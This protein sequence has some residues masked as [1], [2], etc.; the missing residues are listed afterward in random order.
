MYTLLVFYWEKII[1]SFPPIED[2]DRESIRLGLDWCCPMPSCILPCMLLVVPTQ[3]SLDLSSQT[4]ALH[5]L[6]I[7]FFF[8]HNLNRVACNPNGPLHQYIH[9]TPQTTNLVET[10]NSGRYV[11]PCIDA[12]L[13]RYKMHSNLLKNKTVIHHKA[14]WL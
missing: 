7:Y 6:Y 9:V 10:G 4:F 8:F 11:A 5:T 2:S 3:D 1:T 14:Q 12:V 13:K